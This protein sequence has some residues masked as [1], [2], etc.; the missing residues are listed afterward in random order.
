VVVG[1]VAAG[2]RQDGD[3]AGAHQGA[4]PAARRRQAPARVGESRSV[5]RCREA[6]TRD[7]PDRRGAGVV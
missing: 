4:C 1:E 7:G 3:K 6:T 2:L 5:E